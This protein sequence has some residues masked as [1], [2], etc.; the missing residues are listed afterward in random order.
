MDD[1]KV[2]VSPDAEKEVI[3]WLCVQIDTALQDRAQKEVRWQKWIKQYE[4]VL[5]EKKNFPWKNCSN[6][7]MPVTPIAVETIHAR[8]VNTLFSIRP[9]IQIKPKKKDSSKENCSAIEQFFDQVSQNVINL[10]KVGSQWFLEKNKMGTS[11]LKP[12]WCYDKKKIRRGKG[13]EW[14]VL[15]DVKVEVIA[16]EDLIYPTNATDIQTC[17][18]VAQRIRGGWNNISRKGALKIYEN[19]DKVK[20][21]NKTDTAS[22]ESGQDVQKTKEDMERV[23]RTSPDILK[24]YE[25]FEIYFDY[26]V[27]GDGFAEQTVFTLHKDS[28]IKLR[29]IYH[30]YDHGRRP[31]IP[32]RYMERVGRVDGKGLCEMSEFIQDGTN[33]VVNQT[34]DNMTIANAKVF[35]AQKSE[36]ENIPKDGIYPGCTLYLDDPISGYRE[37]LFGDVKQSNFALINLFKDYHERRTKVTDYTLG[38]ESSMMKS[39]ATATGT[40]ALL[41]ESGRHFDLIINNSRDAL[42]ELAYQVIELYLQ[43]KPEK[44]FEVVG[45]DDKV[46]EI[47]LPESVG[48]LREDY[49]FYCA[50]TS[51]SV[52][53]EIEKQTNLL[54]IQQLGGIFQQMIQLLMM[55]DNPQSQ[56][57]PD[58]KK[59]VSEVITS[60]YKMAEDLI[61][62]FEKVDVASYLPEIP[63]IVKGAYGQNQM[64]EFM[65]MIMGGMN[66]QGGTSAG[67]GGPGPQSGMEEIPGAMQG[68]AGGGMVEAPGAMQGAGVG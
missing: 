26:D 36:K 25:W 44:I 59:F 24:E 13:F 9:F 65:A 28:R 58:L 34:L 17:S 42:V 63:D 50:A 55:I 19:I 20:T 31:F 22:R 7:S 48:N 4:E 66:G 40:M 18:F 53:K 35:V 33:T 6:L 29:W 51:M 52:N 15:D 56:L 62:S 68:A 60:Y 27:D 61:R 8:E 21:F 49:E 16:I 14:K 12:Y 5:P 54:L 46:T 1:L 57:P 10:Y 32:N 43:Y 64:N 11:Y 39:R 47:K 38:R 3:D 37:F 23:V 41:Q 30:P 2:K 45:K 67:M